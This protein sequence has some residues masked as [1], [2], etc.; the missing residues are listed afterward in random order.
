MRILLVEDEDQIRKLVKMNLELEG[1]EVVSV[2]NGRKAIDI[3][4]GQHFDL[5][6]LNRLV[7][8]LR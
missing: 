3:I 2:N 8:L 6:I 1:F 7:G 5:M 4:E